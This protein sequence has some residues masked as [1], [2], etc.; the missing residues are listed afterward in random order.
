MPHICI[1]PAKARSRRLPNKNFA[2][3]EGK[4]ALRWVLESL[5]TSE[6]FD[7]II[8]S[9]DN[10]KAIEIA[11]EAGVSFHMRPGHL[12]KD[13][14][15]IVDV[16]TQL[17]PHLPRPVGTD[18]WVT[19]ALATAVL[20]SPKDIAGACKLSTDHNDPVMVVTKVPFHPSWIMEYKDGTY[21]Y[22]FF[23]ARS[24]EFRA[25]LN[26]YVDAGCL[27]IFPPGVFQTYQSFYPPHLRGYLIPRTRG[28]DINEQEDLDMAKILFR[29]RRELWT[30][31]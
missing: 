17:L 22:P 29:S 28:V 11:A 24:E 19:I 15:R 9:S 20:L 2:E 3:I 30:S 1:V 16:V 31:W 7:E 27:N 6:V 5:K 23:A 18:T 4:P 13:G 26:L 25:D 10:N 12:S 8:V 21:M 14:A